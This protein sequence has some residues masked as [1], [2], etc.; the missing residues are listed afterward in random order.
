MNLSGVILF[1]SVF[2]FSYFAEPH[3]LLRFCVCVPV[4]TFQIALPRLS[5][6]SF[7]LYPLMQNIE[8]IFHHTLFHTQKWKI[9]NLY[10]FFKLRKK[11]RNNSKLIFFITKTKL[12]YLQQKSKQNMYIPCDMQFCSSKCE[13]DTMLIGAYQYKIPLF[14]DRFCLQQTANGESKQVSIILLQ[15]LKNLQRNQFQYLEQK[16]MSIPKVFCFSL[17]NFF[18]GVLSW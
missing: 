13:C 1:Y 2:L 7:L 5:L 15:I 8:K 16:F 18:A 9:T 6:Y 17:T 3:S 4:Y 14:D 11:H 10:Y 12:V